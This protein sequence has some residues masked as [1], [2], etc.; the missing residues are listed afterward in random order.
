MQTFT[1]T[2]HNSL[3]SVPAMLF[4]HGSAQC[5]VYSVCCARIVLASSVQPVVSPP[6]EERLAGD[7]TYVTLTNTTLSI[8]SN[9]MMSLANVLLSNVMKSP[10][11][12]VTPLLDVS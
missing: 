6:R 8:Q 5:S 1:H 9:V 3:S 4:E 11:R 10:L 2:N 7:F 12:A